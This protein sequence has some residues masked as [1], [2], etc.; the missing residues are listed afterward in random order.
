[1][2][3]YVYI[4]IGFFSIII[5]LLYFYIFY[6]KVIELY[7]NKKLNKHAQEIIP[8]ID[9]IVSGITAE[10]LNYNNLEQIKV[11]SKDKDKRGI[12]EE[13]MLYHFENKDK[14]YFSKLTK[15]CEGID[16]IKYEIANLK[17]RNYF[18]K[19]LAAKNLGDLRGEQA[20]KALLD[21]VNTSNS[22]LKYNILLAL[23]KIGDEDSFIKAFEDIDS[24]IILS[25][26]SL[27]E[28]VDTFEGD[29]EKIYRYMINSDNSFMASVF[30]KSA[31]NLKYQILNEDISK[32]LCSEN[33]ELKISAV[34]AIGS[35]GD[36]VYLDTI[37]SLLQ[38]S[39]WE[40]RAVTAKILSNFDSDKV[41]TP[42][43][44]SLTDAQWYVRYNSATAILNHKNG[45]NI[46]SYVF[47]GED[48]FAKD[49][50]I[51]AIE[52]SQ[53]GVQLFE[54]SNEPERME[55]VSQ[56]NKYRNSKHEEAVV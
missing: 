56:I 6:E 40:V 14:N 5:V 34:K 36:E 51:S 52:N 35:M 16:I 44:N 26:R 29:K 25:E 42:L 47:Q 54:N 9:S 21:E 4:S 53:N 48:K 19:A 3:Q 46:I 41:L 32:Y 38:D 22:D 12:I 39:E 18:H 45:I 23:A 1:M 7:K 33:K 20:I 49:I 28:V 13:R 24:A 50:I 31:G 37:I 15:I 55:L 10:G 11:L 30:I 8:L 2:D 27:I 43:A 17:N